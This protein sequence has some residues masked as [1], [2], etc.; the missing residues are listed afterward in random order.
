MPSAS[1]GDKDKGLNLF[2]PMI[3][4]T[5]FGRAGNKIATYHRAR[6]VNLAEER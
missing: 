5:Q 6:F 4:G 2:L 1:M 3:Q